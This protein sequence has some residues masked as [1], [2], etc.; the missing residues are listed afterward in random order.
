MSENTP[1]DEAPKSTQQA[2]EHLQDAHQALTS[3]RDQPHYSEYREELEE[4]ITKLEMALN[5]LGVRSGGL[6]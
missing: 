3:L 5:V 4:A 2:S 1:M 6:L